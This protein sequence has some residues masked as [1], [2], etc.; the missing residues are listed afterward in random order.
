METLLDSSTLHSYDNQEIWTLCDRASQTFLKNRG[1]TLVDDFLS[2]FVAEVVSEVQQRQAQNV[3][4]SLFTIIQ[5][6]LIYCYCRYW[7]T[8]CCATGTQQQQQ[9][10]KELGD[11]LIQRILPKQLRAWNYY[12]DPDFL[13]TARQEVLIRVF[14]R[15]NK[16]RVPGAFLYWVNQVSLGVLRDLVRWEK[17]GGEKGLDEINDNEGGV[18]PDVF[19]FQLD[20]LSST[21]IE[22]LEQALM[23]CLKQDI[24]RKIILAIFVAGVSLK[25]IAE[26]FSLTP[27]QVANKKYS[28]LEV[29]RK[30]GY[31]VH[32]LEDSL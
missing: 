21:I 10:F 4:K 1:W 26:A 29:L 22:R 28:A 3:N 27:I 6:S 25:T 9:A 14:K 16:V 5:A 15:L 24:H 23:R 30:C 7:H 8:I 31:L 18:I 19:P 2:D 11:H 20:L 32:L 13:E 12:P 17:R